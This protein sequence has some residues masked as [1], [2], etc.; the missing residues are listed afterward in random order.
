MQTQS[1]M[2]LIDIRIPLHMNHLGI[3]PQYNNSPCT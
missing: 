2:H 3:C 1:E